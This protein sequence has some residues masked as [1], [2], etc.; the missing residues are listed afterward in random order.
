MADQEEWTVRV[1]SEACLMSGLCMSLAPDVFAVRDYRSVALT[2]RSAPD[3]RLLE[4]AEFCPAEA[5]GIHR[6][7]GG[8]PV[9][10]IG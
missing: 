5:I 7:P 8:E 2:D 6:L 1:D 3:D 4:A 9:L 10:G